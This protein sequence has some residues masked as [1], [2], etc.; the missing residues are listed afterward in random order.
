MLFTVMVLEQLRACGVDGK[1]SRVSALFCDD[2][3]AEEESYNAE[4]HVVPKSD[5]ERR[6]IIQAIKSNFLFDRTSEKQRK[7]CL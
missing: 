4:D 6:S 5:E 1:H 3:G 7:V 2:A